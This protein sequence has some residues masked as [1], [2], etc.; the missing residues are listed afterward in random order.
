MRARARTAGRASD[1]DLVPELQE[2]AEE[3]TVE[4][5]LGRGGT[6]VV[7]FQ[8]N[9]DYADDNAVGA[10]RAAVRRTGRWTQP[11]L[12]GRSLSS[13]TRP[14]VAANDL[15]VMAVWSGGDDSAAR[16]VVIPSVRV[17]NRLLTEVTLNLV[18][19]ANL[20]FELDSYVEQ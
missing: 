17:G 16:T 4:S 20:V 3:Y 8:G 15:G 12:L 18:D 1:G 2:L 6:A 5:E 13:W 11:V 14:S 10:V 7:W 19:V 9:T